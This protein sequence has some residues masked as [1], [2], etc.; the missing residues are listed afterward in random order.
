MGAY[1]DTLGWVYFQKGDTKR[2]SVTFALPGG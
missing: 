2:R 1:W